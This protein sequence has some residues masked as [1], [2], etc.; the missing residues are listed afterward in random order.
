[1][2]TLSVTD[3]RK[4]NELIAR[5]MGG[6]SRKVVFCAFP[7]GEYIKW[8]LLKYHSDWNLLMTVLEKINKEKESPKLQFG[9]VNCYCELM[10]K[11]YMSPSLIEAT[12]VAVVDAVIEFIKYNKNKKSKS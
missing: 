3:I 4:G 2:K 11:K 6:K 9:N 1:M 12:W 7:N 5:F 8:H 10:G